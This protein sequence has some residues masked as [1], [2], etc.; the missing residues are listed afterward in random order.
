MCACVVPVNRRHSASVL[1]YIRTILLLN[2]HTLIGLSVRDNCG[3]YDV[4][5]AFFLGAAG[6]GRKRESIDPRAYHIINISREREMG[7]S[8][9]VHSTYV[10]TYV[11]PYLVG[12]SPGKDVPDDGPGVPAPADAESEPVAVVGQDNH[13]DLG[14]FRL[15]LRKQ[16]KKHHCTGGKE[17]ERARGPSA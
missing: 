1:R 4:K 10:R 13:L 15:E 6:T 11:Y 14:P 5:A 7:V 9:H 17:R 3:Y 12:C 2:V 8:V 16:T